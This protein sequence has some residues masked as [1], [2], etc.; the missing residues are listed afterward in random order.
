MRTPLKA[1]AAAACLV[2]TVPAA[3]AT[4]SINTRPLWDGSSDVGTFGEIDTAT[5][6]QTITTDAAGG[7]LKSFTFYLGPLNH[8]FKAYVFEWNGARATGTALFESATFNI[9]AD[10]TG[11]AGITVNTGGVQLAADT[12]YVMLFSAS[13]YFGAPA[14]NRWAYHEADVYAGGGFV[15]FNNKGDISRLTNEDWDGPQWWGGQTDDLVFRAEIAPVPE[16]ETYAMMIAGLGVMGY[17]ARRR[18]GKAA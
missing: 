5:Y 14:T 11:F 1:L 16:P 18:K 6:G 13:E 12:Q 9:G 3:L 8:D 17:I 15:F 10:F 4:A 2:F 7:M